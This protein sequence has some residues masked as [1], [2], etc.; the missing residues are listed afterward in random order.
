MKTMVRQL[1][2]CFLLCAGSGYAF[3]QSITTGSLKLRN[4]QPETISLTVP[5][6]GVTGYSIVLPTSIGAAGQLLTIQ[7]ATGST[8]TLGWTSNEFWTLTGTSITTPGTTAG[9][10][11][12]GTSNAQDLVI[13]A[14]ATEALRVIG[15]AGPSQ[16]YIGIGTSAPKA[17]LDIAKTVLLSR[18]RSFR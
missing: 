7:N 1:I 2:L 5:A 4:A 6:A 14:N 11:Y 8:A 13:A 15:S 9:Q 10:Q 18:C 17:G 12:L 3:S 16:G